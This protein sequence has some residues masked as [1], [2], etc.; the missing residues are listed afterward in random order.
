M[1]PLQEKPIIYTMENKPIVT[2]AGDQALFTSL[3]G[4]LAQQ[5]PREP[6]EWRRSYG[7]ASKMIHLEANFVQFK[8]DLLPKEGNQ[9]LLT[10]PFLHIYWTD[11]CDSELYKASVKDD[12]LRWQSL[13]RGARLARLA[14][15][16]GGERRQEE[17]QDQ[18]LAPHLHHG[19]DPQRLL[20]QAE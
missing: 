7:R 4:S 16:A 17:E 11:C 10:F 13:L 6:M 19:Q 2:C 5:L 1:E 18:H 8:E 20:Q 9:S 15:R 12:M 3:Y 14:H